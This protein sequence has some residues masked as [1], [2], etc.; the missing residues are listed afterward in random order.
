[1]SSQL[2]NIVYVL[3]GVPLVTLVARDAVEEAK[4]SYKGHSER[5]RIVSPKRDKIFAHKFIPL[6][7]KKP[8]ITFIYYRHK[9]LFSRQQSLFV[10]D[11]L[12]KI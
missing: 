10:V 6:T 8:P 11:D 5:R 3:K 7:L 1:M 9:A 2:I 4:A 12:L